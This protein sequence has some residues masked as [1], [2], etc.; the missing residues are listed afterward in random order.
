MSQ[1][2]QPAISVEEVLVLLRTQPESLLAISRNSATAGSRSW[3]SMPKRSRLTSF[4]VKV[5]DLI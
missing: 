4:L 1:T 3:G 5:R 2:V